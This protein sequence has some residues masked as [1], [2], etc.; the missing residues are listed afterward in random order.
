MR[1]LSLET[2]S[3]PAFD[4][5][6]ALYRSYGF[7]DGEAFTDYQRSKFNPFMHLDL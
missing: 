1:L 4:P 5:A 2:G 3:G 7:S 6:Q